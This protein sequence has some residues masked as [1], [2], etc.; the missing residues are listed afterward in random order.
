MDV[1]RWRESKFQKD[2]NA[3]LVPLV[4]GTISDLNKKIKNKM[5]MLTS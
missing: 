4:K 5:G 1:M 3:S 2:P